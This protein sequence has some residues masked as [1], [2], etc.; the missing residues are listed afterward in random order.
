MMAV[1]DI[2]K[3]AFLHTQPATTGTSVTTLHYRQTEQVTALVGNLLVQDVI[4]AW[5]NSAQPEYLDSLPDVTTLNV[6][7]VRGIT[8]PEFGTDQAVSQSGNVVS[9]GL[10]IISPRS[11][12]VVSLRTGLIGRSFRGRSFLMSPTENETV[13]GAMS[14]NLQSVIDD[15]YNAALQITGPVSGNVYRMTIFSK[16]LSTEESL[17]DNLVTN[18]IIRVNVGSQR[19]RRTVG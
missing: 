1:N 15:Y 4:D 6:I 13:N 16:T 19:K 14:V 2:F 3:L 11:A 7:Q 10:G 18:F 8:N 12:P 9:G 5:Q 17:V